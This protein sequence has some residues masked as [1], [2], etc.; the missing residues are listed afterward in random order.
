MFL[1]MFQTLIARDLNNDYFDSGDWS[2]NE[3]ITALRVSILEGVG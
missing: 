2:I 3:S 1:K